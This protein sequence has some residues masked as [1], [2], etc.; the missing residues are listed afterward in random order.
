MSS[1]TDEKPTPVSMCDAVGYAALVCESQTPAEN[2]LVLKHGRFFLL[3]T[4]HGDIAPPGHCSL[5]LFEEDTRILSH[6]ELRV[7]GGSPSLLSMQAPHGY[8]GCI[9]LTITDSTFGGNSWDPKN[10]VHI[11]REL[12][13]ADRLIERLTLT[14]YLPN[15][16]EYWVE[17]LLAAD[18]ADIFEIRGWKREKRGQYFAPQPNRN[19]LALSYQGLD[20]KVNRTCVLFHQTPT[21]LTGNRARWE[22]DLQPNTPFRLEWEV[23][24]QLDET[25]S[26]FWKGFGIDE[27]RKRLDEV[28]DGWTGQC[29]Q[30]ST[31]PDE[32]QNL[33][34]RAADDLHALYVD[35]LECP[36]ITAESLGIRPHSVA[37]RSLHL[38]KLFRSIQRSRA[39]RFAI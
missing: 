36:V 7:A 39:T 19:S 6:Y 15:P 33:L 12:L 5:G 20:G 30:W 37:I 3:S 9:D 11:S 2:A 31:A 17:L 18:F 29:T 22:F 38:S 24:G 14:N 8:I 16:I 25:S 21:E 26:G 32:L 34:D 35:D 10:C 28:Y 1:F 4:S 23:S 27:H 13:V